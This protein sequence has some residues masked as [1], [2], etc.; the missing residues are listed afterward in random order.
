[1]EEKET[2]SGHSHR[3][4]RHRH[5]KG[6]KNKFTKFIRENKQLLLGVSLALVIF[7]I[8]S[9][10]VIGTGG[11][12]KK[13]QNNTKPLPVVQTDV[14]VEDTVAFAIPYLPKPVPLADE[15]VT[16]CISDP[17]MTPA[18][19]LLA[20]YRKEGL[21]LDRGLSAKLY[22]EI[23]KMPK[24]CSVA[25]AVLLVSEDPAFPAEGLREIKL[26]ENERSAQVNLL[27]VDT[28]YHYRFD[29]TLSDNSVVSVQSSFRTAASA[30]I[31]SIDGIAN[32]RDIGGWA[33]A[34]GKIIRQGLLY[35][36]SE[37]D[38]GDGKGYQITEQGFKDLMSLGIKFDMDLREQ[39]VVDKGTGTLGIQRKVYDSP[40]YVQIF[41]RDSGDEM[42]E[43]FTDL[44]NPENYPMY[45]HCTH[46]KDRTG[47][48]VFLLEAVLGVSEKDLIRE[49]ELSALY[50]DQAR[51]LSTDDIYKVIERLEDYGGDSIQENARLYLLS[52]GITEEQIETLKTIYL[53]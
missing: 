5:S 10:L 3:H 52:I 29:V 18:L 35:R 11:L 26:K 28:T 47:T 48:V 37:F 46:G 33:Q 50:F 25:S 53:G 40:M 43:I 23:A 39:E 27:K 8:G 51:D 4:H 12:R 9:V 32:V 21:R 30:R 19:E 17:D 14:K 7:M 22:Y 42:L 15:W 2:K 13:P 16:Q 20:P 45:L 24:G 1:M 36:G 34:D 6:G 44:A 31:L 41:N 38:N 49:Y